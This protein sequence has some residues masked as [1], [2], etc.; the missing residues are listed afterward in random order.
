MNRTLATVATIAVLALLASVYLGQGWREALVRQTIELEQANARYAE[1]SSQGA[2][3]RAVLEDSLGRLRQ[4]GDSL[5]QTLSVSRE[6]NRA[7]IATIRA[8]GPGFGHETDRPAFDAAVSVVVEAAE[9]CDAAVA[10]CEAQVDAERTLKQDALRQL[11]AADSLRVANYGRWQ[12]ALARARPNL[13][14]DAWR[15]R[16]IVVPSLILTGVCLA[17]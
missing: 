3:A 4:T 15:A 13:F 17:R 2:A 8:L 5:R 10:N 7:A 9:T 1:D 11:T 14:R 16:A 12:E 6:A